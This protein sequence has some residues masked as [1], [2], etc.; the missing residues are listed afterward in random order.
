METDPP[1]APEAVAMRAAG[2][3]C[4]VPSPASIQ[5]LPSLRVSDPARISPPALPARA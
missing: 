3:T 1:S 2:P 5:T 4:T